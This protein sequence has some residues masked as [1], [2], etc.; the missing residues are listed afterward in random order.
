M[1]LSKA[2]IVELCIKEERFLHF[3]CTTVCRHSYSSSSS[4][5]PSPVLSPFPLPSTV[6]MPLQTFRI[7]PPFSQLTTSESHSHREYHAVIPTTS[8]PS[9][10]S[11][12]PPFCLHFMTFLSHSFCLFPPHSLSAS[13]RRPI[14]SQMRRAVEL[15][16]MFPPTAAFFASTLTG[17]LQALSPVPEPLVRAVLPLLLDLTAA[18]S[19]DAQ[20]AGLTGLA[21]LVHRT[22]L[23]PAVLVECTRRVARAATDAQLP[24][25]LG[26]L[27]CMHAAAVQAQRAEG[28]APTEGAGS[29]QADE[30]TEEE[31]EDE[32]KGRTSGR[33]ITKETLPAEAALAIM[34]LGSA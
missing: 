27:A 33:A 34:E 6:Y 12:Q 10:T 16:C 29:A 11:T 31:E 25:F 9:P 28:G 17:V 8:A 13:S 4:F 1:P 24:A 14:P 26:T 7:V 3:V 30:G 2:A 15:G 32:G 19:P 23:A 5:P 18:A 20:L 22:Q 21:L